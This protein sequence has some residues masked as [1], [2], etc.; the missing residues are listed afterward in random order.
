MENTF[1]SMIFDWEA[2]PGSIGTSVTLH[3]AFVSD[4]QPLHMRL[5]AVNIDLCL[6][7][8]FDHVTVSHVVCAPSTE[9]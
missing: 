7:M 2:Q 6:G 1:R 9:G 4:D 5:V 8:I 3:H